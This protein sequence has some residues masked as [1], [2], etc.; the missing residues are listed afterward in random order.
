MKL[1]PRKFEP[2]LCNSTLPS[3]TSEN[4]AALCSSWLEMCEQPTT[5]KRKEQTDKLENWQ[6]S[7]LVAL[8]S[9]FLSWPTFQ[10]SQS[11]L[12]NTTKSRGK[13][14]ANGGPFAY[15]G[16]RRSYDLLADHIHLVA[17]APVED[18]GACKPYNFFYLQ[19]HRNV[20]RMRLTGDVANTS[21][22]AS[23]VRCSDVLEHNNILSLTKEG[24]YWV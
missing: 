19:R 11:F 24:L 13:I 18:F 8:A 1:A 21:L 5:V 6:T 10:S 20:A 12:S 23:P 22:G 3:T 7:L 16:R 9:A 15:S 17:R 4:T 2:I 14:T